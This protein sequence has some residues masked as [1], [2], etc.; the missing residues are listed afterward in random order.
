MFI[1][2]RLQCLTITDQ[3]Q[4]QLLYFKVQQSATEQPNILITIQGRAGVT[5]LKTQTGF[6]IQTLATQRVLGIQT[7]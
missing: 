4:E 3:I 5:N 2:I 6:K 1:G 7:P